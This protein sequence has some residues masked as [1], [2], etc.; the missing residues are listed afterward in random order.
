MLSANASAAYARWF[1]E[2]VGGMVDIRIYGLEKKKMEEFGSADGEK[3]QYAAY[4][5]HV[6]INLA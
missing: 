6:H 5:I 4:V 3:I 2:L 1:G